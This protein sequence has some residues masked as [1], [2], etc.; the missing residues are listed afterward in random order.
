MPIPSTTI[1]P[2]I[3]QILQF[4]TTAN[5]S[6]SPA[7]YIIG[8]R[9]GFNGLATDGEGNLYVGCQAENYNPQLTALLEILVYGPGASGAAT[10]KRTI[11]GPLT[12]FSGP[13]SAL[14][15]DSSGNIYAYASVLLD[16]VQA[17]A[18]S[19][20]S[21]AADGNVAPMKVIGGS[22]TSI[23]GAGGQIAV[24]SADNIYVAG[25]NSEPADSI[26]I[27]DSG[28]TGNVAPTSTLTGPKTMVDDPVG[29]AVDSV[30]NIYVANDSGANGPSI[31]EFSAG[32]TGN[33]APVRVIA[34][35]TTTLSGIGNLTVDGAGNI[36]V[37]SGQ[38]VLKFAPSE[39]GDVAPSATIA[40]GI[41]G[42][43][44][45]AVH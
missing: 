24:D 36:Y 23:T 10:P 5:G 43:Y 22:A 17:F 16:G 6:T 37:V 2:K 1:E 26:L 19:V 4:P 40:Y 30:G 14:A 8:P 32:S 7:S 27:F 42:F 13:M 31:V 35:S 34:G 18:I 3:S 28:A 12:G 33:T 44:G 41:P 11:A 15:V 20:F 38:T 9:G 21:A 39:N 45:I 25:G 29:L